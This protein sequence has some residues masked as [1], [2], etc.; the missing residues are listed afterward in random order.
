MSA[1]A[2]Q[3]SFL[4]PRLER[5]IAGSGTIETLP[6]ELDRYDCRRAVVVTGATIGQSSLVAR[7]TTMLQDRCAAV[8]TGARQHV[9]TSTVKALRDV[10]R[11][12]DADCL[13][14]LGGGSPID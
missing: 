3:G 13:V 6:A 5:V 1:K 2:A 10:M 11:D 7:V 14:S 4:L 9:P 12:V 8:F